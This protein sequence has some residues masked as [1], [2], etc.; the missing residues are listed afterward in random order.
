VDQSFWLDRPS[1]QARTQQ[2][3]GAMIDTMT[4]NQE[5]DTEVPLYDRAIP[6]ALSSQDSR[7]DG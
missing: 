1:K 3:E 6:S 4:S 7:D 2:A 5:R